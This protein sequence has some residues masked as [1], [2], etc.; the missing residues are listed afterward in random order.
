MVSINGDY[1]VYDLGF[2]KRIDNVSVNPDDLFLFEFDN[3][4]EDPPKKSPLFTEEIKSVMH[5]CLKELGVR[6]YNW[7]VLSNNLIAL[8][9]SQNHLLGL[10]KYY[11]GDSKHYYESFTSRYKDLNGKGTL[12]GGFGSTRKT[13]IKSNLEGY[14]QLQADL[15]LH[16]K[17][18]ISKLGETNWKKLPSSIKEALIDLAFNK[19]LHEINKPVILNAIKKNDWSS[20]IPT[21]KEVKNKKGK[22]EA[23]LYRRSLSR[24]ILALRDLKD[25]ELRQAKSQ[26]EKIY[27]DALDFYRKT[28]TPIKDL[29]A[30][31]NVYKKDFS[32]VEIKVAE[33][34][35]HKVV[36][37]ETYWSIASRYCPQGESINAFVDMIKLYNQVPK[38]KD[39]L[40]VDRLINIPIEFNDKS[41]KGN[42]QKSNGAKSV[43][44]DKPI[45]SRQTKSVGNYNISSS[46][47]ESFLVG[48]IYAG[49]GYFAVA[50]DLHSKFETPNFTITELSNKLQELNKGVEFKVGAEIKIPKIIRLSKNSQ[51]VASKVGELKQKDYDDNDEPVFKKMLTSGMPYDSKNV[52]AK[53]SNL[54][55]FTFSYKVEKSEGFY[56]V[57]EKFDIDW[58][59]L[60]EFNNLEDIS[61]L[62][63]GQEIKIPKIVYEVQAGDTLNKIQ[64][65]FKVS[66]ELIAALNDIESPNTIQKGA[67]FSLPGYVYSVKKGD[68]LT[69]IAKNA[70]IS[71]EVLKDINDLKSNTLSI[72]QNIVILFNDMDYNISA[73]KKKTV[74]E[75]TS[76]ELRTQVNTETKATRGRKYFTRDKDK[77]GNTV[78]TRH[79]FKRTNNNKSAPL[80]NKTIIVNAGHG[81]KPG[82]TDPD[83]GVVGAEGLEHECYIAYDNAMWLKDELNALGANV[84]FIQ[85]YEGKASKGLNLASK[86]AVKSRN[87]ADYLVSLHVNGGNPRENRMEIF[88]NKTTGAGKG[89]AMTFESKLQKTNGY[90][91]G[92]V[93]VK[94][95]GYQILKNAKQPAILYEMSFM[96]HPDGRKYL[97]DKKAQQN[98][99]RVLAQAIASYVKEE[100]KSQKYTV[101][102][103]DTLGGIA[104]KHKVSVE[105]LR[106]LNNISGNNIQTGQVLKLPS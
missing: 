13:D 14:Q 82:M 30:V 88:Y 16:G 71:V 101:K 18:V 40:E 49:K 50:K 78:A 55:L 87:K 26:V 48:E 24:A 28:K 73:E 7:P 3:L 56:R 15:V 83:P 53:G 96:S 69:K 92:S 9:S 19:G 86:E 103:G 70:G 67:Y 44:Q 106:K 31:W 64:E 39:V 75:E 77:N 47:T 43:S 29:E 89:L 90:S 66:K 76:N 4:E 79:V 25:S 38:D 84:I 93:L 98:N 91:E 1:K 33:S 65:K 37:G 97:K 17:E 21:L 95:S 85:G 102:P 34:I 51:A 10:I 23:G 42:V 80:Y 99:M 6:D 8:K 46:E 61:S 11:E 100:A 54:K 52:G 74:V 20:I 68:N 105:Q 35:K 94:P 22:E 60:K 57:A 5:S 59:T 36:K 12:T 45:Q 72:G 27:N 41:I 81:Y 63:L 62:K 32:K 2:T 104:Q 58:R